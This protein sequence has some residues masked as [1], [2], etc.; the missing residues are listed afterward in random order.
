MIE[1]LLPQNRFMKIIIA[2]NIAESSITLPNLRYVINS[3]FFKDM[4][5]DSDSEMS[6]L[7]AK[8]ISI[9]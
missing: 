8:R 4:E 3:G 2:T 1:C 6:T 5:F 7:N 9:D